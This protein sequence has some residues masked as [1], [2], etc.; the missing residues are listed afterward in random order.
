[1]SARKALENIFAPKHVTYS[2][3]VNEWS[4]TFMFRNLKKG[5]LYQ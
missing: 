2:F 1:M 4:N 3:N 5:V